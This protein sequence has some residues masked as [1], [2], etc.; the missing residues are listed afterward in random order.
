MA[1]GKTVLD[2]SKD[3]IA[4]DKAKLAALDRVQ[5]IIEFELDG[6]IVTANKNFLDTVG[7]GLDEIAGRHHSMFVE[8]AYAN[9]VEYKQ[10]WERLDRGEFQAGEFKRVAKDGSEIWIQASYNPVFDEN[11]KPVKVVKFA[12]NITEQKQSVMEITKVLGEMSKGDLTARIDRE[13]VGEFE[14]VR[15]D[16]HA[17]LDR[18]HEK[19]LKEQKIASEN[20]RIRSALDTCQTNV[21]VADENY[22]I[23]Y[24]NETMQEMMR[25]AEADLR[26]ELPHLNANDLLGK[27][28]DVFHKNPS[29]QRQMLDRLTSA[30]STQITVSG[31]TFSLIA[32]PIHDADNNR[33]GTVVEWEDITDSLRLKQEQERIAAENLRIRQALDKCST[34]VMVAD[35]HYNIV[36]MNDTMTEMITDAERDLRQDIPSLD[37]KN[38]IGANID[39]FHKNPSHQRRILDG[40]QSTVE[41]DIKTG[42]RDFHLVVSPVKNEEGERI[43]TVVEWKEETLEKQIEAEMNTIVTSACSGDFS[44]RVDLENKDGFM[45]RLGESMN[46]LCTQMEGAMADI[47]MMFGA[48]AE[49]DLSVRISNEYQ[50]ALEELKNNANETVDRLGETVAQILSATEEVAS[51][52]SQISAG[53]TDLSSRTEQQAANLQQTAASMEQL[54][55]TVKQNAENAQHANQLSAQARDMAT[56]G[57]DIVADAVDAMAKISESSTKISEINS[58]I[59]G[60]AFQTNLL[61]LNAAVEA[62]R[63][64]EAGRGFAVVASEVRSLAQRSSE[65]AK[66]INTLIS[67]S[68]VQV[69]DGVDLVNKTGDSL[70]EIVGSIKRVTDIVSEIAAASN[71]QATGIEEVNTAVTQMDEMTQ[72]NSALVEQNAAAATTLQDQAMSM[73]QQM[74]FFQID[75]VER[76]QQAYGGPNVRSHPNSRQSK[77]MQRKASAGSARQLQSNLATAVELDSDWKEF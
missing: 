24:M 65:A 10:F 35:D 45:L 68:S 3:S 50:G 27:N 51:A 44:S 4:Y 39:V 11:N 23:A 43:G 49:G 36:Y 14:T 69:K 61:A 71:E 25:D 31:R 70:N 60:I 67:Q 48:L 76:D 20:L 30:Y 34:N 12:T 63:A 13:L 9:S 37:A 57:G 15:Q 21:M 5:A 2:T 42:G 8:P 58:V 47:S 7:Y 72:Q 73:S 59:D 54:A 33:A 29:H 26:K 53:T 62:A 16:L 56:A 40:L 77:P 52:A 22:N 19:E 32:S 64:G 74:Q 75:G 55:T 46:E 38:L 1:N 18:L 28:I 17:S 6:T 66:D 41:T